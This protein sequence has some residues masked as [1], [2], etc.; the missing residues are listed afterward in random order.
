MARTKKELKDQEPQLNSGIVDQS[1]AAGA[2][3]VSLE[4]GDAPGTP[5]PSE[6]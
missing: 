1:A 3:G 6:L 2:D 5:S 4:P